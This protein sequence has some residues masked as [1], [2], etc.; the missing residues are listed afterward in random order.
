VGKILFALLTL[1]LLA[2]R[3]KAYVDPGVGTEFFGYFA[4]LVTWLG[5]AF[6]G[7]LLWPMYALLRR[8][9]GVKP[10]TQPAAPPPPPGDAASPDGQTAGGRA[11]S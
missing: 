8:F 2:G 1:L 4:S 10:Q 7:L 6:S 5:A 3:A 11:G 9:R